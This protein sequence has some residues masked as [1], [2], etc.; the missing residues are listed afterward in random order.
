MALNYLL[1]LQLEVEN[2][3]RSNN[4]YRLRICPFF[5]E[6]F[7]A[8][9]GHIENYAQPRIVHTKQNILYIR[10]LPV[11]AYC[12]MCL[13]RQYMGPTRISPQP[14]NWTAGLPEILSDSN[15]EWIPGSETKYLI[16]LAFGMADRYTKREVLLV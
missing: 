6:F 16:R 7:E 2:R 9:R 1:V 3:A 5:R 13:H 11:V 15:E 12:R 8:N 14:R 4:V 10:C